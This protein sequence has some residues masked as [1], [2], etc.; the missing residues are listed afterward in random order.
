[1]GADP[2]APP[3]PPRCPAWL[4]RPAEHTDLSSVSCSPQKTRGGSHDA[5]AARP[6]GTAHSPVMLTP[7]AHPPHTRHTP[8]THPPRTTRHT[9]TGGNQRDI[10]RE[11]ARKRAE[12]AGGSKKSGDDGNDGQMLKNR[13]EQCVERARVDAPAP[14]RTLTDARAVCYGTSLVLLRTVHLV[15]PT[16]TSR[17]D[18]GQAAGCGR[19]ARCRA[20]GSGGHKVGGRRRGA[21]WTVAVSDSIIDIIGAVT[22]SDL[23]LDQDGYS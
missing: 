23:A 22:R 21:S 2:L 16:Q 18:A 19:Q 4:G 17:A 20:A 13:Q 14:A 7:A 3:P 15:P 6:S 10:D 11:R 12:R 5:Y 9:H 1:M 8:A